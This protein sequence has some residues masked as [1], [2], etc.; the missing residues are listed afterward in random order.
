LESLFGSVRRAA[1]RRGRKE[2][3]L[4]VPRYA[5]S[6]DLFD[7]RTLLTGVSAAFGPNGSGADTD[8]QI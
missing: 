7:T 1:S 3:L 4:F 6:F 2:N 8:A 5:V